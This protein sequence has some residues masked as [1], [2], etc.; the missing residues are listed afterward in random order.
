MKRLIYYALLYTP[1]ILFSQDQKS[2]QGIEFEHGLTWIQVRERAASEGKFIFV[3]A[4]ATWCVPC[5]Q[6][7]AKVYNLSKVG[8]FIN[9]HFLSIKLQLDTS[10]EDNED[11]KKW[12]ETAN[13]FAS[14]YRISEMPTYLFFS[15]KG[16]I[17]HRGVGYKNAEAFL[18]LSGEALDSKQQSYTLLSN[19]LNGIRNY[20]DVATTATFCMEQ[21]KDTVL[22]LRMAHDYMKN[23]LFKLPN[24]RLYNDTTLFFIS[25]FSQTSSDIGF[26]FV[27]K[28]RTKFKA[29]VAS[30]DFVDDYLDFIIYKE[31][32]RPLF[33][34]GKIT[35]D[36]PDPNWEMMG[37]SLNKKFGPN[38]SGRN[39]LKAKVSWFKQKK[40]W[41]KV[42][43]Y[44]IEKVEK[45]G[46]AGG[47]GEGFNLN[48]IAWDYVFLHSN[49]PLALQKA[50]R[51]MEDVIKKDSTAS[52]CIDTY[53]NLLYKTGKVKR[54]LLWEQKALQI[55][56]ETNNVKNA[57]E[58]EETINKM[59]K[60]EITWQ[61]Q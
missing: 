9:K 44:S 17:I 36:T 4:Y 10:K 59:K 53:A 11:I 19:Y 26:Q 39:V 42:V 8:D 54:A 47:F 24:E 43:Q 48:N 3:D 60:G 32:L 1:A 27:Y 31:Y 23:Y 20:P 6:M 46:A 28:N 7:D 35:S 56:R 18:R 37:R 22:A 45:Y 52:Y 58:Y 41:S 12:H 2:N 14:R 21:L 51:W 29:A 38:F 50:I 57:T 34:G 16:E 40:D 61:S 15:P 30:K 49:D 13:F 5:K 55:A 33:M 25:K